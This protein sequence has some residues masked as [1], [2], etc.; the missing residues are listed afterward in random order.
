[1][2]NE[3]DIKPYFCDTFRQELIKGIETI[4]NIETMT[5]HVKTCE[6]CQ[7]GIKSLSN[8]LT[9]IINPLSLTKFFTGVL[10]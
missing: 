4:I 10:K 3:I 6:V 2:P 8:N 7:S 9:K 1:M 5:N